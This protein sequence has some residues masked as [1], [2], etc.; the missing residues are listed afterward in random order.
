M[1]IKLRLEKQQSHWEERERPHWSVHHDLFTSI[2]P[3]IPQRG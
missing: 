2:H 3:P 1:Q